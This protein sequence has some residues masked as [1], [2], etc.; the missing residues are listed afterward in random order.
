VIGHKKSVKF[1]LFKLL[2]EA[3]QGSKIEIGVMY[4]AG[5]APCSCM[6]T[7]WA[8]ESAEVK[9]SRVSHVQFPVTRW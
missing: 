5:I 3:L 9:L 2:G 1:A 6:H 4:R 8:H 7:N